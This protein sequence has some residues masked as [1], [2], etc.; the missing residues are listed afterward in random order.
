M[1]IDKCMPITGL[2]IL[3]SNV[4]LKFKPKEIEYILITH[5]HIEHLVST[6]LLAKETG[7]KVCISEADIET[8]EKGSRTRYGLV[9]F[10][11]FKAPNGRLLVQ[12]FL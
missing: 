9:G 5:A 7:V 3:K 8:A 6:K 11:P 4:D 1:L 12:I 10:K 2:F